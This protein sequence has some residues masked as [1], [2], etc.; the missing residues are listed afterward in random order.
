MF[1]ADTGFSKALGSFARGVDLFLLECSF[2][3]NKP[4]KTH[5]EL[6]E[7]IYLARYSKAKKTVL[8]H[9]YP[10]WDEV[11]FEEEVEKFSAGCEIIE[12]KDGLRI[13]L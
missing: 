7:A 9:L 12:A 3:K 6:A 8:T 5:I 1:T 4:V 11:D 13:S 10:E 2:L